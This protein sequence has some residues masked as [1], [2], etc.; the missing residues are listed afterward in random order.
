MPSLTLSPKL[1]MIQKNDD[2]TFD[3]VVEM[4][5]SQGV[6]R[7]NRVVRVNTDGSTSYNGTA[8]GTNLT[9]TQMTTLNS[10]WTAYQNGI[11]AMDAAVKLP[12]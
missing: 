7:G 9:P 2:G 1:R 8:T 11:N 6:N 4:Q 5:D 10:N 3:L 12:F